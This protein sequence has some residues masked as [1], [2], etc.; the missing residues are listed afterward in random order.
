MD[1]DM[2]KTYLEKRIQYTEK[3]A[4]KY[5]TDDNNKPLPK[6]HIFS[7]IK[8]YIDNFLEKNEKINRLV[9]IPGL[10]GTG[11]TTLLYQLYLYLIR[12]K[13]IPRERILFISVDDLKSLNYD[14]RSCIEIYE[15]KI[16]FEDLVNSKEP[17][18]LLLDEV[19]H[20]L[21]WSLTLKVIYDEYPNIFIIAT[22]SSALEL[23]KE[24][25]ADLARRAKKEYLFPLNF[26]E[27]LKISKKIDK[28]YKTKILKEKI[29]NLLKDDS[30][31]PKFTSEF[32]TNNEIIE[33][34]KKIKL[35]SFEIEDFLKFGGFPFTALYK[36][37]S[38]DLLLET[39]KKIAY[40][41]IPTINN[42]KSSSI[43]DTI[44]II[45]YLAGAEKT[46]IESISNGL[47]ISKENVRNILEYLKMSSLIFSVKPL[48]SEEKTSRKRRKYYFITPTIR[49]MIKD[50]LGTFKESDIGFLFEEYIASTLYKIQITHNMLNI[51]VFYDPNKNGAD[52]LIKTNNN[53]IIPVEVKFGK[54]Q[55]GEKQVRNSMKR[56]KSNYGI[57]IGDQEL[58]FRDNILYIPKELFLI[59]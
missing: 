27:Y 17:I 10:R 55:K 18:F 15:S 56:Y 59:L 35:Y 44:K 40:L 22:G 3:L 24:T 39:I 51:K 21:N 14:L 4:L 26:I 58:E 33:I 41:D 7:R 23:E 53:K 9:I 5:T 50:Y 30:L 20:D 42:V 29:L 48:G 2:L 46:S 16:L 52:F 45:N 54:S 1:I 37:D 31:I 13:N 25:N 12:K 19:N 28:Y 6:R 57:I 34:Y 47:N 36:K 8:N 49:F 11:K 38:E 43:E 32:F